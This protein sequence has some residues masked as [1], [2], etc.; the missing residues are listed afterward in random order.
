MGTLSSRS[1][2]ARASADNAAEDAFTSEGGHVASSSREPERQP[3][4]A[5]QDEQARLMAM[6]GIH[7]EGRY[8]CFRSYRYDRLEDAVAYARLVGAR[9]SDALAEDN[10]PPRTC[11]DAV[12]P[13]TDADTALMKALGVSFEAGRYVFEGFHY[14]RLTDALAYAKLRRSPSP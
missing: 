1:G 11:S 13:P 10:L 8:Y 6:L 2:Q 12:K 4:N 7:R 3:A 14:D 9:V 5:A